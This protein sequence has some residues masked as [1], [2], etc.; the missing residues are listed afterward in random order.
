ML[1]FV[2]ASS[3]LILDKIRRAAND[4][5]ICIWKWHLCHIESNN[6]EKREREREKPFHPF[7][8]CLYCAHSSSHIWTVA[9]AFNSYLYSYCTHT[10]TH[11]LNLIYI[12]CILC[13]CILTVLLFLEN[14]EG[15]HKCILKFSELTKY[16]TA[17]CTENSNV[18][19]SYKATKKRHFHGKW[20]KKAFSF[21]FTFIIYFITYFSFHSYRMFW[22]I[23]AQKS[24]M[25][26]IHFSTFQNVW[27]NWINSI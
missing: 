12:F 2:Y 23:I 5:W 22:E 9:C 4:G 6:N 15:V 7:F 25:F 17:R 27:K 18:H 13:I 8:F 1:C 16:M 20:Q 14:Y 26:S 19:D 11:S 21:S 3:T 10:R 24:L